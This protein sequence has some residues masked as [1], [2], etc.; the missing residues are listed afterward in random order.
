MDEG[1]H[2]PICFG[3]YASTGDHRIVAMKC[4]HLFGQSCI[5]GWF[6]TKKRAICPT[7]TVPSTKSQ[8]RTIFANKISSLGS[9]NEQKLLDKFL[10]E[11][12]EKTNLIQEN[13]KLKTQIDCL[14][15]E[16]KNL[17]KLETVEKEIKIH[18][19]LF[20]K[21]LIASPDKIGNSHVIFDD[22]KNFIILT[23]L[24]NKNPVLNRY[25]SSSFDFLSNTSFL[26]DGHISN[27]I[28]SPFKDGLVLLSIGSFVYLVNSYSFCIVYTHNIQSKITALSFNKWD[29]NIFYVGDEKGCLYIFDLEQNS[30]TDKKISN[31]SIHSICLEDEWLCVASLFKIYKITLED[32]SVIESD[33]K[34]PRICT[35][36]S[37]YENRL[38]F[39]FRLEENTVSYLID[40]DCSYKYNPQYKQIRRHR[41]KIIHNYLYLVDDGNDCLTV[42]DIH[43]FKVL[44]KYEFKEVIIDFYV[45][46]SHTIILTPL[47]VYVYK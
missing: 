5:L 43:N 39:T 44:F 12:N 15:L 7:C 8:I 27:I 30:V 25:S 14:K 33:I 6:G 13:K 28:M 3:E 29:R 23:G 4:G 16:L 26:H 38:L 18:M 24:K 32:M 31:F 17:T 22:V 34:I 1:C 10:I 47:Y 19:T 41:D 2:C 40:G 46:N 36:M 45:G 21:I 35:N 42:H 11:H 37:V 9:E 20:K